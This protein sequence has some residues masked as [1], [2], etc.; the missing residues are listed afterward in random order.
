MTKTSNDYSENFN[1]G[2]RIKDRCQEA[3]NKAVDGL[4]DV[5]ENGY[6]GV[7]RWIIY[8][9]KLVGEIYELQLKQE[10]DLRLDFKFSDIISELERAGYGVEEE[11]PRDDVLESEAIALGFI[12]GA[13]DRMKGGKA[14]LYTIEM[15]LP[16]FEKALDAEKG[17]YTPKN[18]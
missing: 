7:L 10:D 6:E 5:V 3:I 13:I 15:F 12:E 4:S 16:E 1:T 2:V 9:G 18:G 14:P 17:G 8:Y 11:T